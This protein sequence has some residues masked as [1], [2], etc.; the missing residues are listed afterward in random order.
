M[1]N[2]NIT[3]KISNIKEQVYK[4]IKKDILSGFYKTR[5]SNFGKPNC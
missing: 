4:I 3:T 1:D 2:K 5:K